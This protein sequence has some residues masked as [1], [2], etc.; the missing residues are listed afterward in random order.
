MPRVGVHRDDRRHCWRPT[1]RFPRKASTPRSSST[2]PVVSRWSPISPV[3]VTTASCA[4]PSPHC[5]AW[6]T[7]APAARRRTP[8]TARASCSRS[9]TSSS[10]R[11]STSSC[12]RPGPTRSG[13]PS[14]RPIRMA[15]DDAAAAI[16]QLAAEENLRVLGW[17]ALPVDP[18]KAEIGP[19]ARAVMPSFRQLFVAGVEDGD[20][21]PT[22]IELER[23][24]FC[25]RKRAEHSTGVYFPSL[26]PRTIVYKGM[27]AEPQVDAFYP[28]LVD[29]PRDQRA[30]RGALP[31]LHQHVPGL[32]AGPPL[33]LRRAQ[34][35]DQHVARQPEL[36]GR[37][38]GAARVR[39]HP[40]RPAPAVARSSP[41]TPAT[42]R[43][44]TR[45]WSCCTWPGAA[46]RTRC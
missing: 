8:A 33:P 18:D 24:T 20:D 46:S 12:P 16:E 29:E 6:N 44:S 32:A 41:R 5:C 42:R 19:T 38:R 17:R 14:C 2:T 21:A 25:L 4:R 23:R 9:R 35:R 28:D 43:P 3:V 11:S 34:R 45:C 36:D 13:S 26:S 15:A 22:G 30:G 1:L 7:A 31:V 37:P 40:R 39:R 27:L 10:V